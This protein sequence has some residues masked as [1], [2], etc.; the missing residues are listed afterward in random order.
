MNR[1]TESRSSCHRN[2]TIVSVRLEVCLAECK[3]EDVKNMPDV[4]VS[5]LPLC[6][7]LVLCYPG[8]WRTYENPAHGDSAGCL[9]ESLMLTGTQK[10]GKGI[11]WDGL[12]GLR[13]LPSH[14]AGHWATR[15]QWKK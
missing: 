4:L 14:R 9:F 8:P 15:W 11:D 5:I 12:D 6:K 10:L 7:E 1:A 3:R 2:C 13:Q